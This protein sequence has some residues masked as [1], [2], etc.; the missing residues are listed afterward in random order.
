MSFTSLSAI[1]FFF[2]AILPLTAA[3]P[4][5][6]TARDVGFRADP[7]TNVGGIFNAAAKAIKVPLEAFPPNAASPASVQIFGDFLELKG[8]S[9][10]HFFADMDVDCDGVVRT[11]YI[12]LSI[13]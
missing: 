13:W 8:V 4:H 6:I 7:A 9:A 3:A 5:N 10:F 11:L 2:S 1:C 12:P